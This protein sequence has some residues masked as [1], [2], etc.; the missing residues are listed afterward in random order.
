MII[1]SLNAR[2]ILR[3]GKVNPIGHDQADHAVDLV[4]LARLGWLHIPVIVHLHDHVGEA[5]TVNRVSVYLDP[6]G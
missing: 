5:E 3:G 1:F 6:V 4:L 2:F